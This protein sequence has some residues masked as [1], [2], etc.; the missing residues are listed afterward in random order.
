MRSVI[1]QIRDNDIPVVFCESTVNSIP[2]EMVASETDAHFG[3]SL[4]VDSLTKPDGDAPTYLAMLETN[5]NTIVRAY[6]SAQ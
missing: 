3:G 2:M 4:Y 5:V 6:Q 1:R